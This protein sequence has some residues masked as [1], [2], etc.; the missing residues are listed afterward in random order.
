VTIKIEE[1]AP[2]ATFKIGELAKLLQV[3]PY[4]LRYWETEFA[5][6][7]PKKTRSGQRIY[8]RDEV[9]LL[10]QIR[11]L[12]YEE[13]YTI[14]GARRQLELMAAGKG[15]A[16]EQAE[17]QRLQ[18]AKAQ[19]EQEV[20]ALR[21]EMEQAV[22]REGLLEE[23]VRRVQRDLEVSQSVQREQEAKLEQ[24]QRRFEQAASEAMEAAEAARAQ[25]TQAAYVE[26]TMRL[27][28]RIAGLEEELRA[29]RSRELSLAHQSQQ[30][31]RQLQRAQDALEEVRQ[32][33][34]ALQDLLRREAR[35]LIAAAS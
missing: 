34:I 12:L 18:A 13:M 24:M 15:Q 29:A 19:L 17:R 30:S 8:S 27:Q 1:L 31:E 28:A 5:Q 23:E 20:A 33:R 7:E 10:V 2:E 3:E 11:A 35:R 14:A 25:D 16:A 22:A 6:L 9:A 32:R 4:V 21:E 26:E